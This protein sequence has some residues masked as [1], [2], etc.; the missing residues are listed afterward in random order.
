M[1]EKKSTEMF[2]ER[3]NLKHC[4]I[5]RLSTTEIENRAKSLGL[6]DTL[7]AS[8]EAFYEHMAKYVYPTIEG[9]DHQRLLYYFTL[10]ENCGCSPY[11]KHIIKPDSHIKLLKKL[12]AVASGL[13]Y[14]RMTDASLNPLDSLAPVLTSHNVLAISKLALRIPDLEG[15]MLSSSAVHAAWLKKLFW[16]GDPQLLKETPQ[17]VAEWCHA[18]DICRKYFDRL[19]PGDLMTFIDEI[20]FTSLAISKINL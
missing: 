14:K 4:T 13:D 10:L 11:I 9:R 5:R 3:H 6:Y 12:K 16:N 18:Y 7:K 17:T 19:T 15:N 1:F 20:T 8:P 2:Q